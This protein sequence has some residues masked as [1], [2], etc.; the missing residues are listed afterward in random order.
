MKKLFVGTLLF[1]FLL[2]SQFLSAQTDANATA[3]LKSYAKF[4]FVP[5]DSVLFEDNFKN[6][7]T[8]EIPSLWKATT[9]NVEI[10]KINDEPVAGF[11]DGFYCGM[12]PRMKAYDYLPSRFTIEF[13]YLFRANNKR[14]WQEV[15]GSGGSGEF[16][17]VFHSQ[18]IDKSDKLGDFD[19]HDIAIGSN[20]KVNFNGTIGQY[21]F[22]DEAVC[23][24][25]DKWTHVSIAV[26]ERTL[27]IYLNN[28]RVL[29]MSVEGKPAS[30]YLYGE[31]FTK[32]EE[33]KQVFFRN[34]RIA[35]GQ[36]DPY[37][38]L[39]SAVEGKFIAR[40]INFD[41][42]KA[43]LRPESMGE[44]NRI[45][46][47]MKAH[48]ELKFE[49]GGHSDSDGDDAYNLKLSQQR[50]DAVKNQLTSMG[51]EAAKLTAKGYGETKPI[52]SNDTPEGKANNR[53][54]EFVKM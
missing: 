52:S 8:D 17:V 42:N 35:T 16:Y 38:Q 31:G 12:Y 45:V 6:E 48:G 49:I 39:T 34:V 37:K 23:D 53:R 11:L 20:G 7:A 25:C 51:I 29:N 43:T 21:K 33:S 5:G 40:G 50:A 13:D 41:Y 4:D 27:K 30:L 44:L 15:Q 9:G 22:A 54:V 2:F 18:D 1:S 32:E 47:M 14:T 3:T 28:Q 26:T 24:L 19:A 10:Q 36:K 46:E